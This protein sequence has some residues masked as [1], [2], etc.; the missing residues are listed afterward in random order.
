VD[1]YFADQLGTARVVTNSSGTILDDSDYCPFG[2]ECYVVAESS[3][4]T[5]KFTGKERD[6]ETGNDYLE[7]RF[8]SSMLGRFMSPD[9]L[10]G[11]QE[12]PQTLNKYVYVR[13]NPLS[14]TDPTGLDFNLKCTRTADNNST[15]QNG[16]Q[17]TILKNGK[18]QK[19][20]PT[21]VT[22]AS[23]HDSHSGNTAVVNGSGVM[24][25]T[26]TGTSNQQTAEG[27]FISHTEAADIQGQ[28]TGWSQ[29]TF[30]IDSSDTGHGVLDSGTATYNGTG[31][32][33]GMVNAINSMRANG[34]GPF[35]YPNEAVGGD[36]YQPGAANFRFST[37]DSPD[38]FNNGPSPHFPVLPD[39]GTS[40]PGFHIDSGTGPEHFACV[41]FGWGC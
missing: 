38:L 18:F 17:G 1:Y 20:Q 21:V 22:S 36:R 16:L 23:L 24:I 10:G 13:N 15:C 11:H 28:G 3:G 9:P 12:D 31:G 7:A 4:N 27:V 26:G 29:F 6:A 34:H 5:Y 19:F 30:R 32:H 8:N 37:G 14:L 40:V 2:R 25:T 35:E 33:Q 39:L 41:R